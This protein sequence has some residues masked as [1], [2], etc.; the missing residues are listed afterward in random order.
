[1][2]WGASNFNSRL[3]PSSRQLYKYRRNFYRVSRKSEDMKALALKMGTKKTFNT[4]EFFN[5]HQLSS[6]FDLSRNL[7]FD[8]GRC[9]SFTALYASRFTPVAVKFFTYQL[10]NFSGGNETKISGLGT[11]ENSLITKCFNERLGQVR[12]SNLVPLSFF[13]ATIKK[14]VF[15]TVT[16]DK[17]T[18][19]V[20]LWYYQTLV[21]FMEASSGHKVFI[22]FNPFILNALTYTDVARSHAWSHRLG[23]FQRILGPKFFLLE[24]LQVMHLAIRA[25]DPSFFATWIKGMLE[26]MGF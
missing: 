11:L 15:K 20:N 18:S 4:S 1:M 10:G 25:K 24:S 16:F 21:K 8:A 6:S 23:G 22:K 12:V 19:N 26:R 2:E 7:P 17:F 14:R 3:V 13:T 9:Y 5:N